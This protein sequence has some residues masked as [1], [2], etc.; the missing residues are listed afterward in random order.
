MRKS[1]FTVLGTAAALGAAL[2]TTTA[3]SAAPHA[4]AGPAAG[5]P[6]TTITFTVSTGPCP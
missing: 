4:R 6:D 2:L 3:A 5:D 1:L